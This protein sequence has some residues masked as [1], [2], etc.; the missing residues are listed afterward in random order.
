MKARHYSVM[1]ITLDVLPPDTS[2]SFPV[3]ESAAEAFPDHDVAINAL[4]NT[5]FMP[6]NDDAWEPTTQH[7]VSDLLRLLYLTLVGSPSS[8]IPLTE[9]DSDIFTH[10]VAAD[11]RTRIWIGWRAIVLYCLLAFTNACISYVGFANIVGNSGSSN[12][13]SSS[14]SDSDF[15]NK[16]FQTALIAS[17]VFVVGYAT[18]L[19]GLWW[20]GRHPD[21]S[22]IN[23]N[24]AQNCVHR[25]Y[26]EFR[27]LMLIL[28]QLYFS[29]K[30]K[31]LG[32]AIAREINVDAISKSLDDITQL[33]TVTALVGLDDFSEVVNFVRKDGKYS[34][35]NQTL[36]LLIL[37]IPSL[38]TVKKTENSDK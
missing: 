26:L 24:R 32:V 31:D 19:A 22:S 6:N 36:K 29:D 12:T 37:S 20:T 5:S 17:V 11:T 30:Y 10:S 15:K 25:I 3:L 9:Q 16:Q 4:P 27:N 34:F 7:R 38:D 23:A 35:S 2:L 18:N 14:S 8:R 33:E 1:N 13:T 28:A 21:R